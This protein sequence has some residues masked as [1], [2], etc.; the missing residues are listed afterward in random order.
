M[1]TN[2]KIFE[3]I[4]PDLTG[5]TYADAMVLNETDREIKDYFKKNYPMENIKILGRYNHELSEAALGRL[6]KLARKNNDKILINLIKKHFD[7]YKEFVNDPV[8]FRN[9][10]KFNI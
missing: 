7:I 10:R 9:I 8:M 4:I 5:L 2:F 1:I 6:S 3:K